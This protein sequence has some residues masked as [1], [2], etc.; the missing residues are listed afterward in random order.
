MKSSFKLGEIFG[1][2]VRLHYTWFFI[3]VLITAQ[4]VAY[5]PTPEPYI[6]WQRM[7]LGI[8]ASL[9]LFISIIAHELAHSLVA[10]KND[11]PVKDITLFVFGGVSQLT[12][13]ASRPTTEI[14]IAIIGPL[15]SILIAGIFQGIHLLLI[16]ANE[17]LATIAQWLAFINALMAMFNLIPGFPLD[18]GRVFRAITW[19]STGNY[20]QATRI[21]TL[22]GRMIGYVF[23]AGGIIFMFITHEWIS[24]LW[25]AFIGW[26]LET[27]AITSYRQA[28]LH[29]ALQNSTVRDIMTEDYPVASRELS[30]EH[31][32]QDYI[33]PTR[34]QCFMVA[35]E[36]NLEGI[37]TLHNI[38]KVSSER[39]NSTSVG[40][41]MVPSDKL[42]IA[43]PD[44][45]ASSLLDQMEDSNISEVPVVEGKKLIGMVARDSL[46]R[47]LRIRAEL[48]M[49]K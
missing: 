24:G 25:L 35:T 40:D 34:R 5:L 2:P 20:M 11:I 6:F 10:V 21:A 9:L 13:E 45:D 4:L 15:A 41:V 7:V 33:L 19:L 22:S 23:I 29:D 3:F 43:Y 38:K 36:G 12:K 46:T 31:L 39:W 48:G 16:E 17:L 32:V 18:G 30:L 47:L 8:V 42:K 1:I 44:Q 14:L 49:S 28:L 37:I 27:A 26:F